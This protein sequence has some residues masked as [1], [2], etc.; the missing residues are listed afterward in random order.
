VTGLP[1][2]NEIAQKLLYLSRALDSGSDALSQAEDAYV[3]AKGRYEKARA[4][5][6]L[7]ISDELH[8]TKALAA[9][10][11]AKVIEATY[12]EWLDLEV[13]ESMIRKVK[14]EQRVRYAQCDLARSLNA[15]IRVDGQL[16]GVHGA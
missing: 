4:V 11:D 3:R 1:T 16:A 12:Q 7:K 14:E 2:A 9:E 13:A 15:G 8:G 10:R 5:A 6:V